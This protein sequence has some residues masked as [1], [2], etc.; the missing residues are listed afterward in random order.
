MLWCSDHSFHWQWGISRPLE[1]RRSIK[2]CTG[3]DTRI[4]AGM[5]WVSCGLGSLSLGGRSMSTTMRHPC[6]LPTCGVHA[7][8][9]YCDT[10]TFRF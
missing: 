5:V 8:G 2:V 1:S 4:R 10:S 6:G 3:A 7:A 9:L